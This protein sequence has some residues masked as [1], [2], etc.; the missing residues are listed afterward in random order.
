MTSSKQFAKDVAVQLDRRRRGRRLGLLVLLAGAIAALI[1]MRCGIGWGL[2][3]GGGSGTEK[4][5]ALLKTPMKCQIRV[6]SEGIAVD[7]KLMKR[8]DAV[9]ACKKT[10]GALVTVTGDARQGDWDDLKAAL[11]AAQVKI[12]T[13]DQ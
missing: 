8:D 5:A 2:G 10:V 4:G 9:E 1:Y 13:R 7:G 12:F 3:G 6:S 11:D